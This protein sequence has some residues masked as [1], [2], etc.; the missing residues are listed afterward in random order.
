M[1]TQ[2]ARQNINEPEGTNAISETGSL[3]AADV[4]KT[5]FVD[6]TAALVT[7]TLP[8]SAEAG[9]GAEIK[10]VFLTGSLFGVTVAIDGSGTAD[11]L[12]APAGAPANPAITDNATKTLVADGASSWYVTDGLA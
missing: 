1:T 3:T 5:V 7:V 11:I 10:F 4:G 2:Y 9:A 8:R 12:V 6:S